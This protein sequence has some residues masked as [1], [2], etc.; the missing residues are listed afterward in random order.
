MQLSN[1]YLIFA[2]LLGLLA[3]KSSSLIDSSFSQIWEND[4]RGCQNQRIT[5][6]EKIVNAKTVLKTTNQ[7]GIVATLGLPDKIE[8]YRR[9]Q[10]F[11][12]YY[13]ESGKQC[14][15]T[16][17]DYGRTIAFRF[18]AIGEVSEIMIDT[19]KAPSN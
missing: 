1:Y 15:S 10:K 2:A 16:H 17:T 4:K 11:Y 12:E 7:A 18:D 6:L 19:L 13:Y 5:V 14:D 3:C 9:G 8:I